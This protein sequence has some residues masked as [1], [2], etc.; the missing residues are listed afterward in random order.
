MALDMAYTNRLHEVCVS[1]PVGILT[2]TTVR[3]QYLLIIEARAAIWTQ[4]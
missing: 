3:R 4:K 2:Y 1:K